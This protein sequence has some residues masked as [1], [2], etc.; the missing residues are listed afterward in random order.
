[1]CFLPV[2]WGSKPSYHT[3]GETSELASFGDSGVADCDEG[4]REAGCVGLEGDDIL[5]GLELDLG[6]ALEFEPEPELELEL[7]L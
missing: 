5:R 7:E 3:A 4:E 6:L 1:M 2:L